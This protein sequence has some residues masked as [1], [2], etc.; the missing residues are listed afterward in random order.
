[1]HICRNDHACFN[2]SLGNGTVPNFRKLERVI[3]NNRNKRPEGRHI[4]QVSTKVKE[5]VDV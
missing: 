1:M 5:N 3:S 4:A 2:F